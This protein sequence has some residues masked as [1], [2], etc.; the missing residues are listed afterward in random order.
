MYS[1]EAMD[2]FPTCLEYN[3]DM[4]IV[5]TT[6]ASE[7]LQ[8]KR[9]PTS[10]NVPEYLGRASIAHFDSDFVIPLAPGQF[11][12]TEKITF[13]VP[14]DSFFRVWTEPHHVD[15]DLRLRENGTLVRTTWSWGNEES[16]VYSL[17]A[18]AKYVLEVVYFHWAHTDPHYVDPPCF[19]YHMELAIT[20]LSE[21]TPFVCSEYLPEAG[22][23][24]TA[25]GTTS[26]LLYDEEFY[27]TQVTRNALPVFILLGYRC[28]QCTRTI[29][30]YWTCLLPC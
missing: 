6:S 1:Q 30:R 28:T 27:Y 7:C 5:P 26:W 3:F 24:P 8:Y 29:P 13:T 18:G 17:S 21:D 2:N 15:I 11:T 25:D 16:I 22:L 23:I 19:L 14:E 12:L 20:P 9:L 4:Q 10:L